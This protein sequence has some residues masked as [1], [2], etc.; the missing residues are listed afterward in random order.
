MAERHMSRCRISR[1]AVKTDE[2]IA[3]ESYGEKENEE[4]KE[5]TQGR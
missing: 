3:K 1:R 4:E 2:L 5:Q